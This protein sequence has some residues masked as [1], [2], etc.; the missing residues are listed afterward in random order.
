V[1]DGKLRPSVTRCNVP[2]IQILVVDDFEPWQQGLPSVH[3]KALAIFPRTLEIFDMA[4]VVGPFLE[5]ESRSRPRAGSAALGEPIHSPKTA[6]RARHP[7]SK[8]PYRLQFGSPYP[9]LPPS[10]QV[11]QTD[12]P[13]FVSPIVANFRQEESSQEIQTGVM[14][15]NSVKKKQLHV[16]LICEGGATEGLH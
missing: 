10:T 2:I 11:R 9:P 7:R 12:W 8:H 15:R 13:I 5:V 1:C 4:G 6:R 3:S 16:T 14:L